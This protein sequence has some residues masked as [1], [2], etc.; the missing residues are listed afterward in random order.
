MSAAA[1]DSFVSD[2]SVQWLHELKAMKKNIAMS[3]N[4][5]DSLSGARKPNLQFDFLPLK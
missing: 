4:G 2:N 5:A 3:H 1:C